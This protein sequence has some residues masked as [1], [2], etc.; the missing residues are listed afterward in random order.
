MPK[1][2]TDISPMCYYLGEF[3]CREFGREGKLDIICLRLGTILSGLD[4]VNDRA[5]LHI[6]DAISAIN[7]AIT[8]SYDQNIDHTYPKM[9]SGWNIFHIQSDIPNGRYLIDKS[10]TELG[11]EPCSTKDKR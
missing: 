2:G 7:K 6:S 3:I 10:R 4:K 8:L 11:Y 1:P 9:R 5:E